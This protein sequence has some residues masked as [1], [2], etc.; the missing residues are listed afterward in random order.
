MTGSGGDGM[1]SGKLRQAHQLA[2]AT[3]VTLSLGA[4]AVAVLGA[5]ARLVAS[6]AC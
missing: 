4:V 2:V 6:C 1:R 3:L 5:V